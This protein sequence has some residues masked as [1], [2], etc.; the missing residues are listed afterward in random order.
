MAD[1]RQIATAQGN[2]NSTGVEISRFA[3]INE[4]HLRTILVSGTFD[5]ATVIYQIS[6]DDV[7]YFDVAGADTITDNKAIN[8]EHRAP[9]HR[10]NVSGGLGSEAIDAWVI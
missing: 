8:V 9:F 5:S 2:G 10:I 7:T 6:L 1:E 3:H 4:S